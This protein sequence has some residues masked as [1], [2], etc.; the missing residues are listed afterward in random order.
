[1]NGVLSIPAISKGKEPE[2]KEAE[3]NDP[4]ANDA[5]VKDSDNK[6]EV[7]DTVVSGEEDE[8]FVKDTQPWES[9]TK[10]IRLLF[11]HCK[12]ARACSQKTKT[13]QDVKFRKS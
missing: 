7:P 4:E 3:A 11:E 6:G 8:A 5:E 13:L 9:T 10:P 2:G 12:E 1:M